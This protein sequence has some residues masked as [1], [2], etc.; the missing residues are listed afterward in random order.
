MLPIHLVQPAKLQVV[1]T[2][3]F[4]LGKMPSALPHHVLCVS[5]GKPAVIVL[6]IHYLSAPEIFSPNIRFTVR[7][8]ADSVCGKEVSEPPTGPGIICARM[9]LAMP[10]NRVI[11]KALP[12]RLLNQAVVVVGLEAYLE[13]KSRYNERIRIAKKYVL[14]AASSTIPTD[15]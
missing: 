11:S 1:A 14:I 12:Q 15:F 9:M 5:D 2:F 8:Y 7:D 6:L 4:S 10:I 13:Q 3:I